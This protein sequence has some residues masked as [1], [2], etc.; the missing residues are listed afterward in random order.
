MKGNALKFIRQLLDKADQ[1]LTT[2]PARMIGY[3]SAVIVA[4]VVRIVG[5]VRPG[6]VP[7]LSFDEAVGLAFTA[8]ASV[9]IL[10]ESIRRFVYSPQTYIEDLSDEAAAAHEA[11]HLEEDLRRWKEAIEAEVAAKR[12]ADQQPKTQ[13]VEVGSVAPKDSTGKAN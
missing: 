1:L 13:F 7:Q 10:V 2:E 5:E 12:A 6:L 8:L 11:A 9:T 3:G 4:I